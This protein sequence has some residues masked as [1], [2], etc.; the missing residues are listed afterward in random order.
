MTIID[1]LLK[2][3]SRVELTERVE[4]AE[5]AAQLI[6]LDLEEARRQRKVVGEDPTGRA[7]VARMLDHSPLDELCR[8][9]PNGCEAHFGERDCSVAWAKSYAGGFITSSP[10]A[11]SL[12]LMLASV[13]D[14]FATLIK[15]LEE[16]ADRHEP[17]GA[18][19]GAAGEQN[20]RRARRA[21]ELAHAA[22]GGPAT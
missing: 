15:A 18:Q 10:G 20:R 19:P 5:R 7:V 1:K 21:R 14:S 12:Q 6:A 3:Q 4:V 11:A 9:G 16:Y 8:L 2:R 17:D 13:G 22:R